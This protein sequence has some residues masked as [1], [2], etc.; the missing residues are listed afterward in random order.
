VH[1]SLLYDLDCSCR[2]FTS[3]AL[4]I[5]KYLGSTLGVEHGF[6]IVTLFA[7]KIANLRDADRQHGQVRIDLEVL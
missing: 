2:K 5:F 6:D 7:R 3:D 4:E 1:A